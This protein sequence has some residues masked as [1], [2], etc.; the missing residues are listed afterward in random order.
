MAQPKCRKAEDTSRLSKAE[1]EAECEMRRQQCRVQYDDDS[2]EVCGP[3][4]T[5]Q[6]RTRD[7]SVVRSSVVEAPQIPPELLSSVYDR[8]AGC[9]E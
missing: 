3:V 7:S 4:N 5:T 2:L 9:D 1:S 8:A 6:A